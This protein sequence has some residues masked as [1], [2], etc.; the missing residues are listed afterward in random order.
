MEQPTCSECGMMHPPLKAGEKCPLAV[1]KTE[2]GVE[3][4]FTNFFSQMKNILTSNIQSKK[5]ENIDKFFSNTIVSLTKFIEE[6][7]E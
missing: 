1:E 5:I 3:L 6:Y 2:K 4:D 7:K